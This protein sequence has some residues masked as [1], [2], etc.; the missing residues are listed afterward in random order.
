MRNQPKAPKN[1]GTATIDLRRFSVY[2]AEIA[3]RD[4]TKTPEGDVELRLHN[5]RG[6][7]LLL[8]VSWEVAQDVLHALNGVD[9]TP[10]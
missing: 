6:E 1:T 2:R 10:V 7:T 5:R 9:K 8:S 3:P 4:E